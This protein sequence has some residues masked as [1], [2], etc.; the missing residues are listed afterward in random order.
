MG[1]DTNLSQEMG[2]VVCLTVKE[3]VLNQWTGG[4]SVDLDTFGGE[5]SITP[6]FARAG[7]SAKGM[8]AA[9]PA[10]VKVQQLGK[11]KQA[12]RMR[13]GSVLEAR[14]QQA[15]SRETGR[16]DSSG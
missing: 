15:L 3:G 13:R 6:L 16:V 5:Q 11:N 8:A 10:M 7:P 12:R 1:A 14:G 9:T 4:G 2:Q